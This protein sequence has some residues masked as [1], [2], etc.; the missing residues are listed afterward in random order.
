M[1]GVL[2]PLGKLS[3]LL[4][5]FFMLCMFCFQI[6]NLGLDLRKT[7]KFPDIYGGPKAANYSHL[8]G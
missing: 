7:L 5:Q 2:Y 4:L 1:M 6:S 3:Y 8:E